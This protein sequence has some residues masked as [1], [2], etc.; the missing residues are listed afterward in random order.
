MQKKS[1]YTY[2]TKTDLSMFYYVL[3]LDKDNKELCTIITPVG[4]FKYC[5]MAMGL[6]VAPDVA[7]PIIEEVVNGLDVDVYMDDVGVFI[8]SSF[9]EHVQ[10]VEQVLNWLEENNLKANPMK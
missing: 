5:Q 9:E 1:G 2:F 8:N 7:Q 3:E 6:K 10:L 4:K